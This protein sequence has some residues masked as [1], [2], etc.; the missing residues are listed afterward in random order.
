MQEVSYLL[1]VV[2]S[3]H[4]IKNSQILRGLEKG[5]TYVIFALYLSD[6]SLL[7]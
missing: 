5:P 4:T 3:L 7:S 6:L 2:L 1:S